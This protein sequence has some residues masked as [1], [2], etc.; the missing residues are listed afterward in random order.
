[1]ATIRWRDHEVEYDGRY[2]WAEA[3]EVQRSAGETLNQF[4]DAIAKTDYVSDDPERWSL[5]AWLMVRRSDP[6]VTLDDVRASHIDELRITLPQASAAKGKA[7]SRAKTT[8]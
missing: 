8:A 7:S 2:T 1:M 5:L 3:I 4:R 6:T